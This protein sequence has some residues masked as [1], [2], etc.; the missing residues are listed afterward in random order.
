MAG[1]GTIVAPVVIGAL[2]H[3][4]RP[5]WDHGNGGD[6]HDGAGPFDPADSFDLELRELLKQEGGLAI[7]AR[8]I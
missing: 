3:R 7:A 4:T 1:I 5:G 2:F 8:R 6:E